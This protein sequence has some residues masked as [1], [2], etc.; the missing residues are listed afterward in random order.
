LGG[1]LGKGKFSVVYECTHKFTKRTYAVKVI[2]KSQMNSG[3]S[4]ALRNEIAILQL[5]NHPNV[6]HLK[7]VFESRREIFIVMQLVKGGDLYGRVSKKK[8]FNEYTSRNI[9]KTL[10]KTTKYLHEMGIVHRDLKPENIMV[11]SEDQDDDIQI[12]D[13]G[14]SK[15]TKPD[16][17]M[18]LPCGTLAYV[19]PEVLR[20]DGYGKEVDTWSIGVI[21]YVLLRGR[22][23]F[24]GVKKSDII[25]RTLRGDPS[26]HDK[27]WD[28]ISFEA[29]NLLSA[30]LQVDVS[31]R[32]AIDDA[33]NH[34][35]F[36]MYLEEPQDH[37][38][39]PRPGPASRTKSL[40]AVKLDDEKAR[41]DLQ[42]FVLEPEA[43]E[44][45]EKTMD[46]H[47]L[48]LTKWNDEWNNV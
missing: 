24:D 41:K 25:E 10:L 28:G 38:S 33:L 6:I 34:P 31:E 12:A 3:D 16:E 11:V 48:R 26:M 43:P 35:W 37:K 9:V 30:L 1:E 45:D 18:E 27:V 5:I 2:D 22:L 40:P 8:R 13:F 14:L 39:R 17:L 23:P 7:N 19:A 21:M 15:F 29:K 42:R 47:R 20:R 46:V 32:I 4:E 36:E 44:E